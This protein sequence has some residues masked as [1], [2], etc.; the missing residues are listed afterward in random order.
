M[1]VKT[2]EI[3]RKLVGE[4]AE[5]VALTLHE[6]GKSYC[7]NQSFDKAILCYKGCLRVNLMRDSTDDMKIGLLLYDMVR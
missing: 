4:N 7:I 6:L 1:Y 3:R 2:L 5:S